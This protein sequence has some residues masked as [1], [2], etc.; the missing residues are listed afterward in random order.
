MA[1]EDK[2]DE[3]SKPQQEST[4]P[5]PPAEP[6]PLV[7]DGE[8]IPEPFR[9]KPVKT[10]VDE[11]LKTSTE[12]ER[13]KAEASQREAQLLQELEKIK[14]PAH[15]KTEEELKREREKEFFSDPISFLEKLHSER[16][17]PMV[18]QYFEDQ[19]KLQREFAKQRIGHKEFSKYE[20]RI[21]ELIKGVPPDQR[22][23]PETWDLAYTLALGEEA[24]KMFTE[25][26]VREGYHVEGV[27][28]PPEAKSA[29]PTLSDEE[30]A[31]A[32]KFG[33]TEEEY[34][35]WKETTSL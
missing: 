5:E 4:Q 3:M 27:V 25:K 28:S 30:R 26:N 10:V 7:L 11:L 33:M 31:V 20:K 9:G 13:L 21:D 29:K 8:G 12:L 32:T 24:R 23:R 15:P 16:T 14:Q 1:L 2:L 6:K 17:A 35:K 34:S 19:S 18:V 22:A